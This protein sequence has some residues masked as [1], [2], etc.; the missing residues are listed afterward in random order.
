[1]KTPPRFPTPPDTDEGGWRRG[2]SMGETELQAAR[3]GRRRLEEKS[4][5]SLKRKIKNSDR[6][7]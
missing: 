3:L 5:N 6:V 2:R 7:I 1:L 4:K